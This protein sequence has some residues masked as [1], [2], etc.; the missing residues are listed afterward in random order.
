MPAS[1]YLQM[2]LA[3]FLWGT[4]FPIVKTA[5][6]F[7]G[8]LTLAGLRFVIAGSLLL[9]SSLIFTDRAADSYSRRTRGVQ[10]PR[11]LT[12]ALMCTTSFYSLLFLGMARTTASSIAAADAAGPIISAVI[13]HFALHDDRLTLRRGAAILIAFAGILTI[14]LTKHGSGSSQASA[15]GCGL[16][17]LG[18]AFN[19]AGTMLVVTYRGRLG[20]DSLTG[21]QML[22]GALLLLILAAVREHPL[23]RAIPPVRFFAMLLWLGFLSAVAFR[24]WYGL[25]RRYKITSLAVYSFMTGL[26]GV[27]L[28]VMFL[29]DRVTP[30]FVVGLCAVI[31]G[32]IL[33]NSEKG[34]HRRS[35][36]AE[37]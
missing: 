1:V 5:L 32:V 37:A 33:M 34:S 17:L 26:W 25:I 10:W 3:T 12:I 18:L 14:A 30:Q 27:F 16:A 11:V 13:A 23:G 7:V 31:A 8:P 20:L 9:I 21:I 4:A 6:Q 24:M 28:S 2:L 15:L 35:I 22:L 29:H 19:S 36:P